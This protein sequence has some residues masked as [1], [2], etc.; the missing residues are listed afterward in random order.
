[1]LFGNVVHVLLVRVL[2]MSMLQRNREDHRWR[3]SN[4]ETRKER[5]RDE[6]RA[7]ERR[8]KSDRETRKE[9]QRDEERATE[10]LGKSDR[11]MRKERQRD[12]D[13][14]AL[15]ACALHMCM[16]HWKHCEREEDRWRWA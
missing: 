2:H 6:E 10:R 5:Q 8:G 14:G 9:R 7:T 11:E 1:V 4:R 15:H 3:K 12:E 13:T 16:P